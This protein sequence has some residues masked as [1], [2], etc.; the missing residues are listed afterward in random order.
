VTEKLGGVASEGAPTEFLVS[1]P[2]CHIVFISELG[3]LTYSTRYPCRSEGRAKEHVEAAGRAEATLAVPT[4]SY[5]REH[6]DRWHSIVDGQ[7]SLPFYDV[8]PNSTTPGST[9]AHERAVT[10]L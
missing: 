8:A 2:S 5:H 10:A 6:I 4:S 1:N 9:L 3:L 7:F